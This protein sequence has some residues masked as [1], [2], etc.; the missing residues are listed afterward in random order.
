MKLSKAERNDNFTRYWT[1][2]IDMGTELWRNA[3]LLQVSPCAQ[4]DVWISRQPEYSTHRNAEKLQILSRLTFDDAV[5]L[6]NNT[7]VQLT[8]WAMHN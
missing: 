6:E 7:Y 4:C 3:V 8:H 1:R 2:L 5:Y